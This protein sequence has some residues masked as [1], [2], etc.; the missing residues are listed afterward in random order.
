MN[1]IERPSGCFCDRASLDPNLAKIDIMMTTLDAEN[2]LERSLFTLYR[3]V[4]VRNLIICDGGSKDTTLE[5]TKKFPRVKLHIRPDLTTEGKS[6]EFLINELETE[7]CVYLDGDIE[8][9]EG[10]YDKMCLQKDKFD[11]IENGKV[12]LAWHKY[13][14]DE[15]KLK[16]NTRPGT[17]C[18]LFKKEALKDFH[19]DDDFAWRHD[20]ILFRQTAERSGFKYGKTNDTY[21]VH[22]ETERI[23][24]KSDT[25][26]SYRKVVIDEPRNIIINEELHKKNMEKIAKGIVK[27]LD[28]DHEII[29]NSQGFIFA[30]SMLDRKWIEETN[31]VWLNKYDESQ[32]S[33]S[34]I[35]HRI[36]KKFIQNNKDGF[37]TKLANKF[38][39][40]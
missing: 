22:N 39:K 20:D 19:V 14:L 25:S 6:M 5:I 21:H 34:K 4:P 30:I 37:I 33:K 38:Y 15:D 35:K 40:K 18:H 9:A 17:D 32:S 7:W 13:I 12:Y 3:E 27:Y 16:S 10:W 36:Y 23:P 29:K 1:F 8:L 24:Y 2:Y 31:P 11:V 28:P 26:K